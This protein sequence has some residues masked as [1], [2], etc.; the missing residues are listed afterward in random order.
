MVQTI[1]SPPPI[2]TVRSTIRQKWEALGEPD[3]ILF[4]FK[5]DLAD[6]DFYRVIHHSNRKYLTRIDNALT[7][8]G[9]PRSRRRLKKQFVAA[10]DLLLGRRLSQ[11]LTEHILDAL[12]QQD[13]ARFRT[14]SRAAHQAVGQY[15]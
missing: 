13:A 12:P 10:M 8:I 15:L 6:K 2:E 4:R 7:E 11:I 3:R 14:T 9:N 1:P 5:T